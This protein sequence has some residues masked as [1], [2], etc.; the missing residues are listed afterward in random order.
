MEQVLRV[1][2][3]DGKLFVQTD[4]AAYWNYLM[5][6]LPMVMD[7]QQVLQPWDE[8]PQGRTRREIIATQ[9]GLKIYRAFASPMAGFSPEALK[10]RLLQIPAPVFD[11]R[12]DKNPKGWTRKGGSHRNRRRGDR[13]S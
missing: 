12:H 7:V 1:L 8:D 10:E 6:V 2:A 5:Q 9:K 4:N 11:A 13:R 3:P